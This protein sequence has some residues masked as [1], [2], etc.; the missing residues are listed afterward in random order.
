MMNLETSTQWIS[1]NIHG[2]QMIYPSDFGDALTFLIVLP[3]VSF[4]HASSLAG[5]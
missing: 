4:N 5:G 2:S 3:G 1:I